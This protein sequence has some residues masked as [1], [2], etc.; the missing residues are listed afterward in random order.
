MVSV[1]E[2]SDSDGVSW[3][4]YG[5]YQIVT[6]FHG[7]CIGSMDSDSVPWYLYEKYQIVTVFL[8]ICIG[9]IG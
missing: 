1:R 5:K 6:V 9:S 4:L 8:G 2:V 7:I 3:Y